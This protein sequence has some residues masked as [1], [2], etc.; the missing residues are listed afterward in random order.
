MPILQ[1]MIAILLDLL[2]GFGPAL[3]GHFR[4]T[5]SGDVRARVSQVSQA[6]H[7]RLEGSTF[8]HD[9]GSVS[10]TCLVRFSAASG[11]TGAWVVGT[12]AG[13]E[14]GAWDGGW[15]PLSAAATAAVVRLAGA[16]RGPLPSPGSAVRICY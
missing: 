12:V 13:F 11:A 5:G 15:F 4:H 7:V 16:A 14:T 9:P 6:R 1:A 8:R 3:M 2:S 10:Q